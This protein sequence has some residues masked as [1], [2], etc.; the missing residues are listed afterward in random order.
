MATLNLT[1]IGSLVKVEFTGDPDRYVPLSPAPEF[2]MPSDGTSNIR[3]VIAGKTYDLAAITDIQKAGVAVTN[4]ANFETVIATVFPNANTSSGGTGAFADITGSPTDNTALA[5]ALAGKQDA[6]VITTSAATTLPL[7]ASGVYV[8]TGTNA[9]WTL[10]GATGLTYT[11]FNR[12]TGTLTVNGTLF[13]Q[14]AVSSITLLT[15]DSRTV[16]WDGTYYIIY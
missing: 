1:K 4:Q 2:I 10:T 16:T 12:G 11:L 8:F 7:T 3:V 6:P 15:G 13:G 9:T 5:T 14:A